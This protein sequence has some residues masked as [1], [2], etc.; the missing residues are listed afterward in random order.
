[1][2]QLLI[3]TGGLATRLNSLTMSKPKALIQIDDYPFIYH[4]LKF[5]KS[6]GV[7]QVILCVGHLG[8]MIREYVG[9]GSR[10]GLKVSY[11]FDGNG[12]LGTA[13]A[14]RNA[15][16]MLDQ[17]FF[18]LYGDSYLEIDYNKIEKYFYD[19]FKKSLMVIIKNRNLWDKSNVILKDGLIVEYN[20][21]LQKKE[22]HYI[23]YGISILKKSLFQK[24]EIFHFSDLSDI[25]QH[26][27]I[28]NNLLGYE[29]F[30]RF[31]EIGT[32]KGIKE[33]NNF[34]AKKGKK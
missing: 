32:I 28:S 3:L 17:Q 2:F 1:M 21:S 13:G 19:N 9:D 22:M 31:Y 26:I 12:Q 33:T 11:S 5:A 23:D 20:K 10:W 14:I 30:N 18:V 6:Q 8:E 7:S 27:S 25:Y 15:F 4:Q 29:V 16:K 24:K 34:F